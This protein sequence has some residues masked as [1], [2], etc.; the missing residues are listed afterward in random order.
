PDFLPGQYITVR[1]E[2]PTTPTSPRDYSLSDRPG[3]GHFRISVKR[4][5][6]LAADAPEGLISAYLHDAIQPGDR[7]EVGPPCGV[8]TLDPAEAGI[9][10]VVLLAGGVG[11]TPLLSMFKSLVHTS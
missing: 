7:I 3:V 11:V 5:G 9:R 4:E 8:F 1:A 6:P 2:H 10:P